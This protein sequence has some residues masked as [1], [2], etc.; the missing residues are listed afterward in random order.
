MLA[1]TRLQQKSKITT[2]ML[3]ELQAFSQPFLFGAGRRRGAGSG[4][5]RPDII[6]KTGDGGTLCQEA[7]AGVPGPAIPLA[8]LGVSEAAFWGCLQE[9]AV[10]AMQE[11][12]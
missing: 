2:W 4:D 7:Q 1:R 8:R 5:R 12:T 6:L 10:V 11:V 9:E 3:N